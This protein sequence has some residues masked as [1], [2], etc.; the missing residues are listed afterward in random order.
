MRLFGKKKLFKSADLYSA[1]MAI[2]SMVT[3]KRICLGDSLAKTQMFLFITNLMRS[4]DLQLPPG[5]TIS[6][7]NYTTSLILRP[8]PFELIFAPRY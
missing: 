3:G 5:K 8:A 2:S 1:L 4:F 7:D 6:H